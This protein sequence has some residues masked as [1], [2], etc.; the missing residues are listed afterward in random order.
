[1]INANKSRQDFLDREGG[2]DGID[3]L[4]KS[5]G[6]DSETEDN[7]GMPKFEDL[8]GDIDLDE[9]GIWTEMQRILKL[10]EGPPEKSDISDEGS[11]FYGDDHDLGSEDPNGVTPCNLL[12]A[13]VPRLAYCLLHQPSRN[14]VL[15]LEGWAINPLS[16]SCPLD[17]ITS[18]S[19]MAS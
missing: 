13:T 14:S 12:L 7:S 1:M 3:E 19:M 2:V 10:R 17:L 9:Q 6:A 15:N 5:G 8:E 11:S 16:C 4:G 18:V